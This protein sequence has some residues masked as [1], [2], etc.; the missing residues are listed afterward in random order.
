MNN[1]LE[2]ISIIEKEKLNSEFYFQSLIEQGYS[3]GLFTDSDIERLQFECLSFLAHQVE[4]YNAGD[5]SSIRVEKAQDI[6][7]SNMFTIGVLL[8]TYQYPDDAITA[9]QNE[10]IAELY[11]KGRKRI[12]TMVAATKAIHTKVL[13]NLADT[14]NVFYN[15]TIIDGIKGFFKLYYPD[16]GAHE[17]HITA[18]YPIYNRLPKLAGIEFIHAYLNA[19]CHEN[20]FCLYFSSAD[21]HHLLCG[22]EEDY[23]ELLINIYEPVLTAAIGCVLA[24]TDTHGLDI[25]ENGATYLYSLF[26][27]KTKTEIFFVIQNAAHELSRIFRFSHV[28]EMYIQKSLPII[29]D[30]IEI[31]MRE[32]SLDHVFYTPG[33]PEHRPKL[34]FSFGDKMDNEQYRKVIKEIMQCRFMQDKI[35]I[36]K[37]QVHSLAD[38]EDILLDADLSREEIKVIL[39]E[40][41]LPEIAALLKKYSIMTDI[42]AIEYREQE[43]LI[44]ECLNDYI[45]AL[46]QEQREVLLNLS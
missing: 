13:Q 3:K 23:Q 25:S 19:I 18:D 21:I 40:L 20:Q 29:A 30:K 7:A 8:K 46:P 12:D 45:S 5:S 16:Y 4:R 10:Q 15:A 28:L 38:L 33:Y 27:G 24:G 32:Q 26:S 41:S 22:Y 34:Y 39:H 37:N 44:R 43:Q 17:I 31:A 1:N 35:A 9:I 42:G 36:I 6:M 14:K 11:Q 2:R